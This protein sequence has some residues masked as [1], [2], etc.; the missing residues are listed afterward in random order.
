M[1]LLTFVVAG[2]VTAWLTLGLDRYSR[3]E[4]DRV[5]LNPFWGFGERSHPYSD[6]EA[7]IQ[8]SHYRSRG[9]E[10]QH[11]R[12]YILLAGGEKWCNEDYGPATPGVQEEDAALVDF[13]C[14]KAGKPL[15]RVRHLEDAT[16]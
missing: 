13:V 2:F 15:T 16:R 3:F 1:P 9:R 14:R 4:E 10:I 12:Y 5:V 6:V 7:V 11:T 8:T